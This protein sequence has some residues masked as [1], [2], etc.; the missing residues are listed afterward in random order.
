[1]KKSGNSFV[2][3]NQ[4]QSQNNP[5]LLGFQSGYRSLGIGC[6]VSKIYSGWKMWSHMHMKLGT[7]NWALFV[8]SGA[9]NS[10]SSMKRGLENFSHEQWGSK[11][12]SW[13]LGWEKVKSS[14][15]NQS[16]R[17]ILWV[18]WRSRFIL[19]KWLGNP[20]PRNKCKIQKHWNL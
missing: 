1:M 11:E 9:S 6:W 7:W 14:M 19:P 4:N 2:A 3:E 13:K 16:L 20:C 12:T 18:G 8:K 17:F 10:Y 15:R 5:G